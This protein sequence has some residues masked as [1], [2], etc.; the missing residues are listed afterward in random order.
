[1]TRLEYVRRS[2]GWTQEALARVLGPGFTGGAISLMESGRLKPS[3]RQAARLREA[4][5]I[6]AEA[7]LAVVGEPPGSPRPSPEAGL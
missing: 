6:P 7:M 2:R 3:V 1:M 4:F 5:G